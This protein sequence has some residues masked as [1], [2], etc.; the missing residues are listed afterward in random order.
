MFSES[1]T[2]VVN[3]L[4]IHISAYKVSLLNQFIRLHLIRTALGCGTGLTAVCARQGCS[5]SDYL[6]IYLFTTVDV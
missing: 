2:C 3:V 1:N 6:F 5:T 4:F